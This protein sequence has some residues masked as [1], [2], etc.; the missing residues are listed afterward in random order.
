MNSS[1]PELDE[2]Q[3]FVWRMNPP[4][5]IV[6]NDSCETATLFKVDSSNRHSILLEAVQILTDQDLRISKAY[7]SS[8]GG[9]CMYVFYVTDALGN[10]ITNEEVISSIEK[11]IIASHKSSGTHPGAIQSRSS[12]VSSNYTI[13]EWTGRDRPGLMSD[14]SALLLQMH[15]DIA[16]AEL[17]T[18]NMRVACLLYVTDEGTGGPIK[19][20]DK[21]SRVKESLSSVLRGDINSKSAHMDFTTT[22]VTHSERRLHQ[23]M[24]ADRD[25][26]RDDED[27][28]ELNGKITVNDCEEKGYSV[29]SIE[30]RDRPKLFFDTLCT[31]TDMQYVV[32]HATIDSDGE[33]AFQEYYIRHTDGCTLNSEAE[34]RR[35]IQCLRAAIERRVSEGLRL[36][37]CT[38]DRIGLLSDVTPGGR[39]DGKVI[40]AVKKEIGQKFLKVTEVFSSS[41]PSRSSAVQT[42]SKFSLGSLFF[43][44]PSQVLCNLGLKALS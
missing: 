18:H 3:K 5:V 33:K 30:C 22:T 19:D 2:Y 11:T 25:Y 23:M 27:D 28:W 42:R 12:A 6:D 35:L 41:S 36:E 39:V 44:R 38:S 4:R 7:I 17:W 13:I 21:L 16:A 43:G 24:Y 9:W 1:Q 20:A 31:L 37:L 10:K 26:E 29:V 8:V 32:F 34:R 40:E 15:C 14:I